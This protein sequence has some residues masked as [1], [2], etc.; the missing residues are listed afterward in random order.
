LAIYRAW[1]LIQRNF[2]AFIGSWEGAI[3]AKILQF[4]SKPTNCYPLT[5]K[6]LV[7]GFYW[8]Y[9]ENLQFACKQS[10]EG[11]FLQLNTEETLRE[12]EIAL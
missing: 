9:P 12:L 4:V 11:L 10:T 7:A 8:F 2:F 1:C 5:R 6:L 3:L